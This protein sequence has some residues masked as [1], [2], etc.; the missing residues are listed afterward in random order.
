[1]KFKLICMKHYFI[2]LSAC[3]FLLFTIGTPTLLVAQ[4]E[5]ATKEAVTEQA[6]AEEPALISPGV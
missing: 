4:E 5:T 1:M 2:R 3:L 6:I